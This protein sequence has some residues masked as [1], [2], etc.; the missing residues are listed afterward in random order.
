LSIVVTSQEE[1]EEYEREKKKFW[2]RVV[3]KPKRRQVAVSPQPPVLG[4]GGGGSGLT[5]AHPKCNK[6]ARKYCLKCYLPFCNEHIGE[7]ECLGQWLHLYVHD[8]F[9]KYPLQYNVSELGKRVGLAVTP[10]L[11][12]T[13]EEASYETIVDAFSKAYPHISQFLH[14]L[15]TKFFRR[16]KMTISDLVK[17]VLCKLYRKLLEFSKEHGKTIIMSSKVYKALQTFPQNSDPRIGGLAFQW[18]IS[19]E[20]LDLVMKEPYC[21]LIG[22]NYRKRLF[23]FSM[24]EGNVKLWIYF[25]S[26]SRNGLRPDVYAQL[27]EHKSSQSSLMFPIMCSEKVIEIK[28]SQPA[29]EKSMDRFK[30][31]LNMWSAKMWR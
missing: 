4:K 9:L 22:S 24:Q 23:Q 28:L 1:L 31:Y 12:E 17:Y 5:C 18:W 3:R 19:L 13:F 27:W 8:N 16:R 30:R 10:R 14:N 25:D 20:I 26:F 21:K 2:E 7:H 15:K 6:E 29:L 11:K